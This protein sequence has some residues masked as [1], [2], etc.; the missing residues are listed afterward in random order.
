[1]PIQ[2]WRQDPRRGPGSGA[3]GPDQVDEHV[4]HP[5]VEL[6]ARF[7]LELA[8]S[9]LDRSRPAV[10]SIVGHRVEGV[11]HRQDPRPERDRLGAQAVVGGVLDAIA[12]AIPAF[13]MKL[14]HRQSVRE[15]FDRAEDPHADLDVLLHQV[16]LPR[17]ERPSLVEH[18]LRHAD[19][20]HVV[21]ERGVAQVPELTLVEAQLL[22]EPKRQVADPLDVT[23]RPLVLGLDRRGERPDRALEV[24]LELGLLPAHVGEQLPIAPGEIAR[25]DAEEAEEREHRVS[26]NQHLGRRPLVTDHG[27][28][29]REREVDQADRQIDPDGRAK[30]ALKRRPGDRCDQGDGGPLGVAP[31]ELVEAGEREHGGDQQRGAGERL[32]AVPPPGVEDAAEVIVEQHGRRHQEQQ[33]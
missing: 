24:P 21:E 4:D 14:H 6:P 8:Q 9:L 12:A 10:G 23:D 25:D 5:R 22:A 1:M 2:A 26:G 29:H 16:A 17:I 7:G 28:Q 30:A 15:H 31:T 19:L 20:A 3:L 18:R 32:P 13:L 27:G 33:R 11:D